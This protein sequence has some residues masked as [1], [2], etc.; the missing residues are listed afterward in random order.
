MTMAAA[1]ISCSGNDDKE[2]F[3]TVNFDSDGGTPVLSQKVEAGGTATA[4]ANPAKQGY[5][6]LFWHLSGAT[7]AY[8]FQ[9][10]VNSNINLVA[11][12]EAVSSVEYWQ[13]SWNLNGGAWSANDNHATQV[14][15]GGTLAE[16][17]APTKA[18][19]TF[20]GWYREAALTNKVNFPYNVSSITANFTLYAKWT[21]GGG[22]GDPAGYQMFTS[23]PA[24][25]SWLA[26]Q[27][28]NT[29]ATAY[30]VG[31]KTVNLDAGNNWADLGVAVK[32]S[33]YVDLNLQGCTGT[34]IPDGYKSGSTTYGVFVDC[35]Y[36]KSIHLPDGL[37]NVGKY[38]F[39]HCDNLISVTLPKGVVSIKELAF[40]WCINL[41]GID[42]QVGLQYIE[43]KVFTSC[44]KL[45]YATLPAGLKSIG[46]EA[47]W[48][49]DALEA[50]N[51]PESV[52]A[53]GDDAFYSCDALVSV[54]LPNG[55]K[56]I[57][58]WFEF[59]KFT[60]ITIPSS[61]TSIGSGVFST[62]PLN[63]I[64]MLPTAPPSLGS[65]VFRLSNVLNPA[66][67]SVIIK[68]PAASLN[69]YKTA[70]GWSVFANNIVAN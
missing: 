21:S 46:S 36:L 37:T 33:K 17:N 57:G 15:K 52:T 54:T 4:P 70:S 31:L 6:F 67:I 48:G 8:N 3:Y 1:M 41:E 62:V 55:I 20:D 35:D 7:T 51:I 47:F 68:V 56:F 44:K 9:T 61:V 38:A 26:S 2:T 69:A 65:N 19:N 59:C 43:N 60:S 22:S 14:A 45:K 29:A 30:K 39:Y 49:C 66:S 18:G 32:I 53:I 24:L 64:I 27:S 28:S 58:N 10:P 25:K 34:T 50:I 63:E 23:I 42:L 5:V 13:V 16:P 40:G 12:W 11:K